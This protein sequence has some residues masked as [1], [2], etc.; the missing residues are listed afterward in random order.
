MTLEL[1][2]DGDRVTPLRYEA[3]QAGSVSRKFNFTEIGKT[4]NFFPLKPSPAYFQI[5]A[6]CFPTKIK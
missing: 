1:Q 2:V 3:F 4:R 6:F 5:P